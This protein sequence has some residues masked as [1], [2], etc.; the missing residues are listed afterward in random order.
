MK[1][2]L[3]C[4]PCFVRQGLGAARLVSDDDQ[5]HEQVVREVLRLAVDLDMSQ[6]P[7]AIGQQ[8]HRLIRELTGNEDSYR[9]MKQRFNHL[10]IEICGE[11]ADGSLVIDF[12]NNNEVHVILMDI[13]M[14][15]VNGI[16]ATAMATMAYPNVKVLALTVHAE[17]AYRKEMD[18]AGAHGFLTKTVTAEELH[19]SIVNAHKAKAYCC[20]H[21]EVYA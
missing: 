3:D 8:I 2:Y 10:A 17:D 4:I 14:P 19:Q 13:H 20:S 7:P 15:E 5:I 12:L 21:A 18:R 1:T 16:K 6:T 9:E 11:L